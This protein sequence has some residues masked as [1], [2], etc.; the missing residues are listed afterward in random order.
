MAKVLESL[1]SLCE[2]GLF[3]KMR[4]WELMSASV[5]FLYHPN[6]WI[7]EGQSIFWLNFPLSLM[8]F[9]VAG[10][11]AFIA[12][13]AKHLPETDVWCILY[14]S[15]KHLLKCDIREINEANLLANLKSPVSCKPYRHPFLCLPLTDILAS[16][17]DFR[18]GTN[19]GNEGIIRQPVLGCECE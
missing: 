3:Q 2:L 12:S 11:A 9:V 10:A 19:V 6:I 1:T 18:R 8:C 5:G 14:P 15:L 7:R 13:A 16:A 17:K 4:M